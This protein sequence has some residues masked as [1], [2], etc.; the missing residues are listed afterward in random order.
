[1]SQFQVPSMFHVPKSTRVASPKS[2][3][4]E[5]WIPDH[6]CPV[7]WLDFRL[8]PLE[9][10]FLEKVTAGGWNANSPQQSFKERVKINSKT[11]F[12]SSKVLSS[13]ILPSI[14]VIN[15][16]HQNSPLL[17]QNWLRTDYILRKKMERKS[18]ASAMKIKQWKLRKLFAII[19][20]FFWIAKSE[21]CYKTE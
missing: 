16:F 9:E 18:L 11:V 6:G 17:Q 2:Q 12:L 10:T 20:L 13:F 1:M 7:S 14:N 15:F 3:S 8:C 19:T 21:K 4:P 5:P